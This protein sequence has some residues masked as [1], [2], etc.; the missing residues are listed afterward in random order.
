MCTFRLT[1]TALIL[2]FATVVPAGAQDSASLMRQI[3]DLTKA[4]KLEEAV[5]L[6]GSLIAS[7]ERAAGRDHPATASALFVLGQLYSVQG[8]LDEAEIDVQARADHP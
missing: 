1:L 3:T 5:Q 7:V 8:K 2:A 6:G 4:G